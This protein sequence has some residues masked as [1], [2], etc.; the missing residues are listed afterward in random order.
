M[1]KQK[2]TPYREMPNNSVGGL[3]FTKQLKGVN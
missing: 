2:K 3:F 1:L